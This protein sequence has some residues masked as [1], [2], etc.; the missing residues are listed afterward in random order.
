MT[1]HKILAPDS[2]W[3]LTEGFPVARAGKVAILS[4][5]IRRP[6]GSSSAHVRRR[7]DPAAAPGFVRLA[8]VRIGRVALPAVFSRSPTRIGS[9]VRQS[10]AQIQGPPSKWSEDSTF[11]R[12]MGGGFPSPFRLDGGPLPPT[13]PGP[14]DHSDESFSQVMRA[15]AGLFHEAAW[16]GGSSPVA[17]RMPLASNPVATGSGSCSAITGITSCSPAACLRRSSPFASRCSS[18][19]EWRAD[20]PHSVTS[21]PQ[22]S[23]GGTRTAPAPRI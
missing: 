15:R 5:L 12:H 11:F 3:P 17:G 21:R 13:P 18:S 16:I 23:R 19:I 22:T 1:G 14:A 7:L 8:C 9:G 2:S 20:G 4:C 10:S 6:S